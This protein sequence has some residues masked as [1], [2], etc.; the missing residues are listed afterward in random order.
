VRILGKIAKTDPENVWGKHLMAGMV[1]SSILQD[2]M[3]EPGRIV[4]AGS[5]VQLPDV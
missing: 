5:G 4:Y 2:T 3:R 1:K